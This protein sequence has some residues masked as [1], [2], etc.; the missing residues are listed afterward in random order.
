[1][2]KVLE[3]VLLAMEWMMLMIFI[4]NLGLAPFLVLLMY[5]SLY[6]SLSFVL[7]LSVFDRVK[8]QFLTLL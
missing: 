1:V 2:R 3:M 5:V 8:M 4:C 7:D 6:R